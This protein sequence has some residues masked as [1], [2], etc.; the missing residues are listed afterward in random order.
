MF[1][2][3]ELGRELSKDHYESQVP[4]LRTE[5]LAAQRE[6]AGA[7]FS[8][9]VL[10]NGVEGAG[11]S[12]LLNVLNEW[13]DARYIVTRAFA[14]PTEEESHRPRYWRYWMAMPPRGKIG[15]YLGNWYYSPIV[16]RVRGEIDSAEFRSSLSQVRDFEKTLADDGVLFIKLWLHISK[17]EQKRRFKS[18][19]SNPKTKWRVTRLEKKN[20]K[21]YD[22]FR[23]V[24][25]QT[26]RET[27]TGQSP[28]LVV[29]STDER[30]RDVTVGSH[31]LKR[32]RERLSAQKKRAAPQAEAPIANPKTILDTLDLTK[33]L[34]KSEYKARLEAG[35]AK[36]SRLSRK[37]LARGVGSLVVFEGWDAAGKGG[38]IRRIIH[39][40]DIRDAQVIPIAAPTDEERA[41]HYLWRFWR[42]LPRLGRMTIYD[43]SW[44]GR[45]LV[46]RVEGFATPQE[47][48]RAYREITD[49]EQQLVDHGIVLVKFWLHLS[50]EEQLRRFQE[51]EKIPWKKHK[52][53][54][55][56]YRN[57]EKANQY[58]MAA[59]E[60]VERTSTEFAP[61]TLVEAESKHYAR[62]KVIETLN[63]RLKQALR[64]K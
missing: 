38:C 15:M 55:E 33:S 6:L 56:D 11:K 57:R 18:W 12:E 50:Q 60:M 24:S 49:F 41:Q 63:D 51:R 31:I 58:E 61:W 37:A 52:I 13:L 59:N 19:A 34:E 32:I 21:L 44:Y 22:E 14:P 23:H 43:R 25:E 9:V 7:G 4:E 64:Q 48:Q 35:Q 53:T 2:T 46:E 28:W 26:I 45:L 16:D 39:G 30:Y 27:S 54:D 47:W 5:L 1:E 62:I 29:E 20:A 40:L 10:I 42:H 8:V 36:L 17:R 3:A